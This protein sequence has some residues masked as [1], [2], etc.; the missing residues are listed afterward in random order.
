[1]TSSPKIRPTRAPVKKL[2]EKRP[3]GMGRVKEMAEKKNCAQRR[4]GIRESETER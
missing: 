4:K 1:M 3:A 2:G